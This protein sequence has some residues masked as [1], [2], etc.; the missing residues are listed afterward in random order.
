[1]LLL[2]SINGRGGQCQSFRKMVGSS[3]SFRRNAAYQN[4]REKI[5]QATREAMTSFCPFWR[6]LP[7]RGRLVWV[8]NRKG[9]FNQD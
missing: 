2:Q 9:V 7:R 3:P 1:M 5:C 6:K 8:D 4:R